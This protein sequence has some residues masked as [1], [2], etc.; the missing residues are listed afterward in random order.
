ME[1]L[2]DLD[3]MYELPVEELIKHKE[4]ETFDRTESG[5]DSIGKKIA[6]FGTKNGGVL[7]VGQKDFNNGGEVLGINKKFHKEFSQA[8]SNV[9]PTPL[10]KSKIV[11]YQDKELSLIQIKDVGELRPC[12]YKKTF[13]ERKSDSTITLPPEEVRRYHIT[14][15]GVNMESLPTHASK[16]DIDE[17]ELMNYEKLLHKTKENILESVTSNNSL[18]IRGVVTISKKPCDYLEG[19]FIEIQ[20]YDNVIGSPPI[21]IGTSIKLSKPASLLIDETTNIIVQNLPIVRIYNGAKMIEKPIIPLSVI[22]EIVTNA[23]AH[24]NYRSNEHIRIRIFADCF[25]V[26]NPAVVSE[27]MWKDI[28]ANH[29][30]YHPNEGLYTFLNPKHLYEGRGEGIWKIK[31]ELSRLRRLA[32]EFKVLGDTPSSFYVNISLIASIT[33]DI[34][35]AKLYSMIKGLKSLTSSKVM[36]QLGVSRV[37][38][39]RMLNRLVE[40]GFLYH[41]GNTKTSKYFVRRTKN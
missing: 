2:S 37:T 30:T 17:R 18:T 7:L 6:G 20:K 16:K 32:P 35:M 39:I 11:K 34:K 1:C 26:S 23:V 31:E 40:E 36:K 19:A 8:I 22:R 4:D 14:Y 41:E 9:K 21:P 12:A 25:D 38:A 24:R 29:T 28:L 13:Y 33:K 15:G 10:T 5:Q 27:K 3:I